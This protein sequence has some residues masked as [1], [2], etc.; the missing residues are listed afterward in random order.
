MQ[1]VSSTRTFFHKR[2][3]PYLWFGFLGLFLVLM[4]VLPC[5]GAK[6]P[7]PFPFMLIPVL[8]MGFGAYLMRLLCHGLVDEVWDNGDHLLVK[9]K[10]AEQRIPLAAIINLSYAPMGNPSRVTLT[11]REPGAWGRKIAYI[12]QR[13][14]TLSPDKLWNNPKIDDLIDRID[15]ARRG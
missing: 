10:G 1:R 2:I 4:F 15:R 13:N 9:N 12:P 5:Q 11:L 6:C 7:P 8:M 14:F 3:F